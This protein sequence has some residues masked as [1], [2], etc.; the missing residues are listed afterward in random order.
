MSKPLLSKFRLNGRVWKIQ[1]E[2]L[3]QIC[4]KCG[5]LGHKDTECPKFMKATVEG[6]ENTQA[7]NTTVAAVEGP[8]QKEQKP[9][10]QNQYG[11]WMLVQRAP[12]R[13][14]S[15][16]KG[17]QV[18]QVGN[19]T[20]VNNGHPQIHGEMASKTSKEKGMDKTHEKQ[21]P[22]DEGS[23]FAALASVGNEENPEENNM[24]LEVSPNLERNITRDIIGLDQHGH[25]EE[26]VNLGEN[27]TLGK[28]ME[29]ENQNIEMGE[30]MEVF[31]TVVLQDEATC[32]VNNKRY[33]NNWKQDNYNK[34]STSLIGQQ[35]PKLPLQENNLPYSNTRLS[36]D[37]K[38]HIL[39]TIHNSQGEG[40]E[41]SI[42]SFQKV[43]F[44]DSRSA[45]PPDIEQRFDQPIQDGDLADPNHL[46]SPS[47]TG[48][49]NIHRPTIRRAIDGQSTPV[50]A[51]G[52]SPDRLIPTTSSQPIGPNGNNSTPH[53]V[54]SSYARPSDRVYGNSS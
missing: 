8:K 43:K 25:L 2:G 5:H 6:M 48:L 45:E 32:T 7:L 31:S 13:T 9:E 30:N 36:R 39:N 35:S 19:K 51:Q 23:R 18:K 3:R 34:E 21:K 11:T 1:Y 28:S 16:P 26:A 38:D 44:V 17:V 47:P 40:K 46:R 27:N 49:L 24:E 41:N 22:V 4:F 29:Q 12:R 10:E 54:S 52:G 15:R 20:T 42:E 50:G 37:E 53:G 14:P 33:V